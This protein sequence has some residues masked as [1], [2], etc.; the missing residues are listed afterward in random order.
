MYAEVVEPPEI[1]KEMLDAMKL[2]LRIDHDEE[3]DL[4]KTLMGAARELCE[5]T[6]CGRAFEI[7]R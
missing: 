2:H 6:L 5:S 3:D 7:R 4:I 1:T